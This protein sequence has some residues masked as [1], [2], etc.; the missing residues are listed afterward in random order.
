MRVVLDTNIFISALLGGTLSIIVEEWK[1]D[2]HLLELKRF[3]NIPI[4]VAREFITHLE[5]D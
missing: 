1:G 5:K 3:R 4:I 2:G